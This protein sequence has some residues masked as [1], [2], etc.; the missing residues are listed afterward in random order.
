MSSPNTSLAIPVLTSDSSGRTLLRTRR[1]PWQDW[2]E[3]IAILL[4]ALIVIAL[5]IKYSG[6]MRAAIDANPALNYTILA[7]LLVGIA[8]M[9]WTAWHCV[10]QRRAF[11]AWF[12]TAQEPTRI[13]RWHEQFGFSLVG[14]S[15][16]R[17]FGHG[18][19][20]D[21]EGL[22]RAVETESTSV[23]HGFEHRDRKSVV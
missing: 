2:L 14:E 17:M 11:V 21:S 16:K 20:K 8:V 7:V 22:L 15:L 3:L 9:G 13:R 18:S 19:A 12:D 4:P 10:I 23:L 1:P 5:G 6:F